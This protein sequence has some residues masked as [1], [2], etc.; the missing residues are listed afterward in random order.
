[1]PQVEDVLECLKDE[2]LIGKGGAGIVY[3]GSMANGIDVAIKWL[4]GRNHGF[5]AEIQTLG[6]IRHR[7]I[8]RLL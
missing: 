3:R 6:K 2:N 1:M 5:D 8:V 7:H 4:I